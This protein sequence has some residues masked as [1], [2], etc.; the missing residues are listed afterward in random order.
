MKISLMLLCESVLYVKH[1]M[2]WMLRSNLARMG[3][4]FYTCKGLRLNA[5]SK[6]L[7]PQLNAFVDVY[8]IIPVYG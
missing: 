2:S 6:E 1:S 4:R 7:Y 8:Y 5:G 3:K